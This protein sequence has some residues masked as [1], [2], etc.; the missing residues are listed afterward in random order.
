M[1]L[2][3]ASLPARWRRRAA[4]RTTSSSVAAGSRRR[5]S[6]GLSGIGGALAQVRKQL[7]D[8]GVAGVEAQRLPV[9]SG[10]TFRVGLQE[11]LELQVLG[12]GGAGADL[13]GPA[14]DQAGQLA[15]E[16]GAAA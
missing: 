10:L 5:A 11:A 13:P 3:S 9:Q 12:Q 15:G 8:V 7:A 1:A 16:R 4:W 14:L 2:R 6:K